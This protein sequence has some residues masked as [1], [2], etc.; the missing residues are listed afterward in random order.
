MRFRPTGLLGGLATACA[1]ALA[2]C[3]GDEKTVE[4]VTDESGSARVDKAVRCL[5]RDGYQTDVR[6]IDAASRRDGATG[7]VSVLLD[8]EGGGAIDNVVDV[9]FWDSKESAAQHVDE[10]GGGPLGDLHHE[11]LG[12]VTITYTHHEHGAE[13]HESHTDVKAIA[14]C[15]A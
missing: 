11:R 9:H 6:R 3:G 2:A 10:V 4:T 15:V 12:A 5:Q 13:E 8:L 14:A 7:I 1:L